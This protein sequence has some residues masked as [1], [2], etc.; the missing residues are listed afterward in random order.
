VARSGY[1]FPPG[2]TGPARL[3]MAWDGKT[4]EI[5]WFSESC[6]GRSAC[7]CTV[8]VAVRS[9]IIAVCVSLV[10]VPVLSWTLLA[11]QGPAPRRGDVVL[12]LALSRDCAEINI[13][14]LSLAPPPES[15]HNIL[16]P[17][18][19]IDQLL[20]LL[21][22]ST[23]PHSQPL[24]CISHHGSHQGRLLAPAANRAL[25]HLLRLCCCRSRYVTSCRDACNRSLTLPRNLLVLP[26]RARRPRSGH[27]HV[28]K[29]RRGNLRRCSPL[30]NRC[31]RP[32]LL[33][34][35]HHLLRLHCYPSRHLVCRRLHC[36]RHLDPPRRRLMHWNRQ[37]PARTRR[38]Q[39]EQ[40]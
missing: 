23:T 39:T 25:P 30:H 22:G 38:H 14:R 20:P 32:H 28:G 11:R 33:P 35:W 29:G 10:R 19:N 36:H 1:A 3:K 18:Q 26:Q 34:R 5:R 37:H 9:L 15:L 16:H 31:H 7:G 13:Q 21:H 17:P 4:K 8:G 6:D 2:R 40:L 27:S 24:T 12:S